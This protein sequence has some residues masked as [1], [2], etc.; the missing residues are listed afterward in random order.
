MNEQTNIGDYEHLPRGC[1][2]INLA[3]HK[4][5]RGSLSIAEAKGEV[6]FAIERVFWIYDVPEGEE[7]GAHSHR[8][9]AEVVVPAQ[10]AL[11]MHQ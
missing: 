6:P 2:L 7:R 8:E 4:D 5:K 10:S 1:R 9:C 3:E 11:I